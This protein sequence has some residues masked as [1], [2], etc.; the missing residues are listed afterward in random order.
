M[1]F[2]PPWYA[3]PR[4][5]LIKYDE[6]TAYNVELNEHQTHSVYTRDTHLPE[7]GI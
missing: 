7:T 1:F 3:I 6:A 4:I 5:H 2:F